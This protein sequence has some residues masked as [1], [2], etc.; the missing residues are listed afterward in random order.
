M[1]ILDLVV[2]GSVHYTK[3][4]LVYWMGE[5]LFVTLEGIYYA[6]KY[7]HFLVYMMCLSGCTYFHTIWLLP[8]YS[9]FHPQSIKKTSPVMQRIMI[10]VNN[11]TT[12]YDHLC[13]IS[14]VIWVNVGDFP[15]LYR[16]APMLIYAIMIFTNSRKKSKYAK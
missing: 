5:P 4:A 14:Y 3:L 13:I 10:I 11:M 2:I 6:W 9:Y 12:R 7:Y 8:Y 16:M 15:S 1:L